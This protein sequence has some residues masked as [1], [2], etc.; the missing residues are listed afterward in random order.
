MLVES[1]AEFVWKESER[2]WG[3]VGV[4]ERSARVASVVKLTR[5]S[6]TAGLDKNR[7]EFQT[8]SF[9]NWLWKGQG[10]S[11]I[12]KKVT[13]LN[14]WNYTK[15][16]NKPW[17]AHRKVKFSTVAQSIQAGLARTLRLHQSVANSGR[18]RLASQ[19][20]R[21][22]PYLVRWK[23]IRIRWTFQVK[24]FSC[25]KVWRGDNSQS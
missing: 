21:F 2:S 12:V 18:A 6:Y 23:N 17:R 20:D 11:G 24:L 9:E 8:N 25:W 14:R 4:V 3:E 7:W 1:K 22:K 16:F 10:R 15:Q 5:P 13:N 19:Q